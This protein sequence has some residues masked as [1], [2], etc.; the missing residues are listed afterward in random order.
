MMLLFQAIKDRKVSGEWGLRASRCIRWGPYSQ[1]RS[2]G[3]NY[4]F[5]FKFYL[6]VAHFYVKNKYF[7]FL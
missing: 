2:S 1:A 6:N 4:L 7:I 5:I 3:P